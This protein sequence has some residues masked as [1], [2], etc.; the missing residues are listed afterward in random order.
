[1]QPIL[2]VLED[3]KTLNI[4]CGFPSN[5]SISR[6]A[7]YIVGAKRTPFGAFGGKLKMLSAT[8]LAVHSSIGAIAESKVNKDKIGECFVGNVIQSS[9]DATYMSRHVALK[10]GLHVSTPALSINRLC[11]R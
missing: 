9:L 3:Q 1:M 4:F 10:S 7:I 5:M 6:S 11:G 2:L 8:D